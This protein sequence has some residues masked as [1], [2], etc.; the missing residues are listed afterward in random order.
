[1]RARLPLIAGLVAAFVMLGVN[2]GA[3]AA[4]ECPDGYRYM[5]DQAEHTANGDTILHA[6]CSRIKQVTC[7]LG[8]SPRP[9]PN[10]PVCV[11]DTSMGPA[12]PWLR[13]AA[14]EELEESKYHNMKVYFAG[15]MAIFGEIEPGD[16]GDPAAEEEAREAAEHYARYLELEKEIDELSGK[17]SGVLYW[18]SREK[19]VYVREPDNGLLRVTP[20]MMDSVKSMPG[21]GSP[22]TK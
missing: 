17:K 5:G 16:H 10:G 20:E 22:T 9:S 18:S 2:R 19:D 21:F 11:M 4:G 12:L 6:I 15:L 1:M 14:A 7:R 13:K 3:E 8:Y